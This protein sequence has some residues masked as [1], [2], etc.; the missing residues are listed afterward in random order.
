MSEDFIPKK[1]KFS[2]R[3]AIKLLGAS[4][5]AAVCGEP[6]QGVDAPSQSDARHVDVIV[7]GA[8]F[9]GLTAARNLI[10]SGKKVVLLEARDRVGGRVKGT[11][12]AGHKVDAGGMWVGPTQTK[13]LELI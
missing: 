13:V 9:A 10:R 11:T 4:A 1:D 3:D 12:L 8:G 6:A 2:R 7:V 5:A